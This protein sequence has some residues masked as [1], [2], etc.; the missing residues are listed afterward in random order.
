[1][2][3]FGTLLRA[4]QRRLGL[5]GDAASARFHPPCLAPIVFVI[6]HNS[7]KCGRAILRHEWAGSSG[8]IPRPHRK[9]TG[10]ISPFPIFLIPDFP[11][12]LKFLTLK[13]PATSMGGGDCLPSGDTSAHLPACFI[14]K[15]NPH[16]WQEA[17]PL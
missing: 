14:K 15:Y 6:S 3:A 7:H 2:A 17:N 8:V 4:A 11:T 12:T 1:M 9:P 16:A 13:R 10:P 5:Y